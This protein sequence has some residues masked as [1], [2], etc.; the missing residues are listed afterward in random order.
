MADLIAATTGV[1]ATS[2]KAGGSF[3]DFT[4]TLIQGYLAGEVIKKSNPQAA[5]YAEYGV[6]TQTD[7]AQ[8]SQSTAANRTQQVV[9]GGISTTTLLIVGGAVAVGLLFWF[10]K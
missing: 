8:L 5:Q 1:G 7:R 2:V 4:Q 10:K 6:L 3:M 9:S